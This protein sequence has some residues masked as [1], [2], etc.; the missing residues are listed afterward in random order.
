MATTMFKQSPQQT[1]MVQSSNNSIFKVVES[2]NMD[3][4]STDDKNNLYTKIAECVVSISSPDEAIANSTQTTNGTSIGTAND[5]TTTSSSSPT[6]LCS[7]LYLWNKT[8]RHPML[9]LQTLSL[10]EATKL[11]DKRFSVENN[12]ETITAE[13][14]GEEGLKKEVVTP[15]STAVQKNA[16]RITP[17]EVAFMRYNNEKE[18][19]TITNSTT[20]LTLVLG[21]PD[22]LL[23]KRHSTYW[24]WRKLGRRV[25]LDFARFLE[26]GQASD[27]SSDP[28]NPNVRQPL[29]IATGKSKLP[30]DTDFTSRVRDIEHF[31]STTTNNHH[32]ILVPDPTK[33][34]TP[35]SSTVLPMVPNH[36]ASTMNNNNTNNNGIRL[37]MDTSS[38]Q[39][40][41][42]V[43][44]S[45]GPLSSSS[46]PITHHHHHHHQNSRE[47]PPSISST[48][49]ISGTTS[50]A[51][52]VHT[53]A[54][55][56]D[57]HM[58][59][60]PRNDY[61]SYGGS[62]YSPSSS[63]YRGKQRH[64]DTRYNNHRTSS[65]HFRQRNSN[66]NTVIPN[67]SLN[68]SSMIRTTPSPTVLNPTPIYVS[69]PS[70]TGY[71]VPSSY[72]HQQSIDNSS[73][74]TNYLP[75][76]SASIYPSASFPMMQPNTIWITSDGTWSSNNASPTGYVSMVPGQINP[77]MGVYSSYVTPTGI[78]ST[79]NIIN[80]NYHNDRSSVPSGYATVPNVNNSGSTVTGNTYYYVNK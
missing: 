50:S 33:V 31:H 77:N 72:N 20:F 37:S 57:H 45:L 80:N 27:S 68:N 48:S 17:E 67:D 22:I 66:D 62:N 70:Q 47:I 36:S 16:V 8:R 74:P 13:E 11:M 26:E 75:N 69:Y 5:D 52:P 24:R 30:V 71:M 18:E 51:G 14:G 25:V 1:T 64:A 43:T 54:P 76:P 65:S 6:D 63:D 78:N 56:T 2:T 10:T 23:Q 60:S 35:P 79:N 55:V 19:L 44:P 42:P 29:I 28:E 46:Q 7:L 3:D 21:A 38:E 73:T 61:S 41:V 58:N 32:I 49:I 34:V 12:N 53:T 59:Y 4:A 39:V 9:V 40:H 15:I